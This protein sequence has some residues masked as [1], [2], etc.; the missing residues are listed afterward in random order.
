MADPISKPEDVND[1]RV[2]ALRLLE[3]QDKII[4]LL[5]QQ[6]ELLK[7][8]DWK[9]WKYLMDDDNSKNS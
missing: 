8:I 3:Q 5:G 9:L 6:N 1:P 7:S 2:V 4:D